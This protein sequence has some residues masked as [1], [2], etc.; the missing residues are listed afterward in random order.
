MWAKACWRRAA[1]GPSRPAARRP[2][3]AAFRARAGPSAGPAHAAGPHAQIICRIC[4][5]GTQQAALAVSCRRVDQPSRQLPPP[6]SVPTA[7]RHGHLQAW[8]SRGAR[9][10]ACA[11]HRERAGERAA[12]RA[13][14][15]VRAAPPASSGLRPCSWPARLY[16]RRTDRGPACTPHAVC[17]SVRSRLPPPVQAR[18][19]LA[20]EPR[21]AQV[22]QLAGRQRVSPCR[23]LQLPPLLARRCRRLPL[24]D[25]ARSRLPAAGSPPPSLY[26]PAPRR[27]RHH[28]LQGAGAGWR[29]GRPWGGGGKQRVPVGRAAAA[30]PSPS[31]S[32]PSFS[33]QRRSTPRWRC[34]GRSTA[35]SGRRTSSLPPAPAPAV[36]RLFGG[37]A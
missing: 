20:S 1:C 29:A 10:L 9:V 15:A 21:A 18:R 2:Q 8:A 7:R 17:R 5:G 34:G 33:P 26:W 4:R 30:A 25:R 14:A 22:G 32:L 24:A 13:T 31:I 28:G 16:L 37:G 19:T 6:L 3:V 36:S 27:G 11:L 35:R 23:L 12:S